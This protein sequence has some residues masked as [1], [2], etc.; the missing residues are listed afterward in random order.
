MKTIYYFYVRVILYK[1]IIIRATMEKKKKEKTQQETS[2][3]L[4][5]EPECNPR[6]DCKFSKKA[7]ACQKPIKQRSRKL[8]K[9]AHADEEEV[10]QTPPIIPP[11]EPVIHIE[12]VPIVIDP[13]DERDSTKK[14]AAEINKKIA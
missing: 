14:E 9:L 11:E 5:S 6:P 3:K 12:Q 2:C 4:L 8:S 13:C 10:K 7:N 1:V